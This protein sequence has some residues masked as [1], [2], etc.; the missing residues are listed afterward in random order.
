VSNFNDLNSER[1]QFREISF[2]ELDTNQKSIQI[3]KNGKN[4][5][6]IK[7]VPPTF[8]PNDSSTTSVYFA[9]HVVTRL[10]HDSRF[11]FQIPPLLQ[12]ENA[13]HCLAGLTFTHNFEYICELH[14]ADLGLAASD[15]ISTRRRNFFTHTKTDFYINSSTI[16]KAGRLDGRFVNLNIRNAFNYFHFIFDGLGSLWF[17]GSEVGIDEVSVLLPTN[18][19]QLH[20]DVLRH[21]GFKDNQL[22]YPRI[23]DKSNV[24]LEFDR[25]LCSWPHGGFHNHNSAEKIINI[26]RLL[27]VQTSNPNLGNLRICFS[28]RNNNATGRRVVNQTELICRLRLDFPNCEVSELDFSELTFLE[29]LNFHFDVLIGVHGAGLTNCLFMPAN[30]LVIELSRFAWNPVYYEVASACSHQY[31]CIFPQEELYEN[32]MTSEWPSGLKY[33]PTYL[34]EAIRLFMRGRLREDDVA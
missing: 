6:R 20:L 5:S 28:V 24:W 33:K 2:E 16:P 21:V 8:Y 10:Y 26:R 17:L 31:V 23:A 19:R 14:L 13:L 32:D 34:S 3:I 7:L 15:F 1:I 25:L 4:P 27:R 12:I 9:N 22:I 30:S 11:S 18:L 29:Q